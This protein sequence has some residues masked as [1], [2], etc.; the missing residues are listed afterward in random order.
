MSK[1]NCTETRFSPD[2][3]ALVLI[4]RQSGIMQLVHDYPPVISP[5]TPRGSWVTSTLTSDRTDP[6]LSPAIR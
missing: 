3:S 6:M 5:T 2:D 1:R 4:D